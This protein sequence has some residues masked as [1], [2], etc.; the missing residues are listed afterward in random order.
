[1]TNDLEVQPQ[2]DLITFD[3]SQ[4]ALIK[5]TIAVDATDD[6]LDLFMYQC[7]RTGLDPLARQIHFQKYTN[8]NTQKSTVAFITTIDGYRLIASR[9]EKYAGNS[10]PVFDGSVAITDGYNNDRIK[11]APAKATVTVKK[12]VGGTLCEFSA[13]TYWEEYYPGGSKGHMWRKMPHV[14]LAKCAEASALRKAF[15][16]DL[17]GVY[18]DDEMGQSQP[19]TPDLIRAP[20]GDDSNPDTGVKVIESSA[21]VSRDADDVKQELIT[22][23]GNYP[24]APSE[25]QLKATRSSL[26]KVGKPAEIKSIMNH[27]F[28]I[29][30][31]NDLTKGMC[32]AFMNWIGA[33]ADNGWQATDTA[34]QE[35]QRLL[36]A[37]MKAK[38]Q[39]ELV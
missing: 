15:P 5:R 33:N 30:T 34:K 38:G 28:G 39:Q 26:S 3:S 7:K 6:E 23:A 18:T 37:D 27:V 13:S 32:M 29:T 25:K 4:V 22:E 10:E 16:A 35:A 24:D 19:V 2:A 8:Q 1:M 12:F 9:T 21:D 31:S 11:K 36:T 17:S 14:M 20:G